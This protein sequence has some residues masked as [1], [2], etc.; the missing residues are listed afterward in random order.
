MPPDAYNW[1]I[2][3]HGGAGFITPDITDDQRA[4]YEGGLRDALAHGVKR[5]T[6]NDEALGV[7]EAVTRMLEDHPLFNAGRGG[8]FAADGRVVHD[9]AIMDGRDRSCGAVTG[10]TTVKHPITLARRVMTDSR[11]VFISGEGAEAFADRAGVERVENSYF[12]TDARR[13]D[14]E[15]RLAREREA[16]EERGI[17]WGEVGSTVGCVAVDSRGDVA[18]AT[19]TGG[20]TGKRWGRIGDTPVIGAGTYADNRTCALSGTGE[21]EEFIRHAA[22]HEVHALMLHKGMTLEEATR[23]VLSGVLKPNDGGIIG[24]SATGEVVARMNTPSMTRGRADAGGVFEVGI[25]A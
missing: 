25:W 2:A 10:T 21:G 20:M 15:K 13:A 4:A 24:V 18:A 17:A 14:L 7:V 12:H 23:T 6:D 3:I 19:S 1:A 5:L 11:H 9:A 22:C 8:V 16:G